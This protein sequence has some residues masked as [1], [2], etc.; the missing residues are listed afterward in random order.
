MCLKKIESRA[1]SVPT[2]RWVGT[3]LVSWVIGGGTGK[4]FCP[5]HLLW[6]FGVGFQSRAVVLLALRCTLGY[7]KKICIR[8]CSFLRS[9]V[10]GE[11]RYGSFLL[12]HFCSKLS[13]SRQNDAHLR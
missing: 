13:F 5:V 4:K 1:L 10:A 8:S 6:F 2:V 7:N 12:P 3:V 11:K 9:E